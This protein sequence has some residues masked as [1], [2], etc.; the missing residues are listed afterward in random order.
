MIIN[1]SPTPSNT[2]TNTPT[3]TPSLTSCPFVC[4]LPSNFT[5]PIAASYVSQMLLLEDDTILVMSNDNEYAGLL[6]PGVIRIDACGNLLNRY[7]TPLG[8]GGNG[9]FAKQSD[10]KIVVA[11]GRQTFRI[12]ADYSD[13]DTTFVSGST[14]FF[15][16][17]TGIICNDLDEILI[18]GGIGTNWT[19]SAGTI[20]YN[21]NI[22][23]F[24][25]DGIPD[26]SF[27]G[28]SIS[29]LGG[30]AD[31]TDLKKDY[32]TN[33]I[34]LDGTSSTYGSTLYQ[35]VVRLN[36]D[37]SID[38]TFLAAG[39]SPT[40]EPGNFVFAVEPLSNGQY[41]VGGA[42]QNYSGFT[43]QDFLIRLNNDGSL[44]TT[45]DWGST[46][47]ND[48][49]YDIVVQSSGKIIIAAAQNQVSRWNTNGSLDPTWTIGFVN[50][51]ATS[52]M[53]Y[54]N[55]ALLVG[56]YFT[57]Y[58]SQPYPKMVKLDEDGELNMCPLPTPTNTP[59]MTSTPTI[60]PSPTPF[61][62]TSFTLTKTS[63]LPVNI[64]EGLYNRISSYTGGSFNYGFF[65]GSPIQFITGTA[66]NGNDYLVYERQVGTFYTNI[67][68]NYA[69]VGTP[70]T[71][72]VWRGITTTG[73]SIVNGALFA[74]ISGNVVLAS[75]S[76]VYNGSYIPPFSST[77]A[78]RSWNFAYD[79]ICPTPTPTPTPTP[80]EICP[81]QFTIT[82][83]TNPDVINGTYD[84]STIYSGGS[85]SY[86]YNTDTGST[87]YLVFTTAPDGN[88]YPMFQYYDGVYYNTIFRRFDEYNTNLGFY[89]QRQ[90]TNPLITG[91]ASSV[92][93]IGFATGFTTYSGVRFPK[94]GQMEFGLDGIITYP[95]LCPTPTPT[96]SPTSTTTP[97]MTAT[98]T[99]TPTITPTMTSTSPIITPTNTATQT[100]TQT[101]TN[102]DTPTSTPTNTS[103]PT[104]T[105]EI[106]PSMTQTNTPTPSIT[107]PIETC[108]FLTVRTDASLDVPITGVEVNSV[109]VSY[110]SG[111]TF[112]IIPSS[113]PGYFNTTQTGASVSVVVNYGSNIAGQRIELT[114]C[115]AVVHCCD[116][117]PGGGTCSFTGVDLSC[118][119]NWEIQ[120]YD[121]SC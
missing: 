65:S 43:N 119:C 48:Y 75:A 5:A 25:K 96:L 31:D 72:N 12:K 57:I 101:Q 28:K 94:A 61:C 4:C 107:P 18:V 98:N 27:S 9:G 41:L 40:A 54:P 118:N 77:I 26:N 92:S 81:T 13:V 85:F 91:F 70:P 80:N 95:V 1:I 88:D 64:Q 53:L 66:P 50:L 6:N 49:V 7:F 42:F 83:S 100:Q 73:S 62:E 89:A 34:I 47:T 116:L 29:S 68:F 60:T 46:L 102:T 23:K 79:A 90:A 52:L 55:D 111:G 37:F 84:R 87:T 67:G 17:I 20:N 59:S 19:Y 76:T 117:N 15:N 21:N 8:S 35:G 14:D 115:D 113:Q 86:G 36:N 39:F 109:P 106:T 58:N 32:N 99:A 51:A 114:D 104:T 112:T 103:T 11:A 38:T 24:N 108:A 69:A 2:A 16:G 120:A 10:G 97:T 121:G 56:G 74:S 44:D 33:K 3:I 78:G 63:G 45:F 110:L 22:Y 30:G 93:L 82:N 71:V 105:P